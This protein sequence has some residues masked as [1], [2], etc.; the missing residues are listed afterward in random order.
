MTLNVVIDTGSYV[1]NSGTN[2]I[3]IGWQPC[4]V[5][6][7]GMYGGS[8]ANRG[9]NLKSATM[10]D[11]DC[12]AQ[13]SS[14]VAI[15]ANG[16]TLGTDGFSLG[17]DTRHNG[18]GDDYSYCALRAGPHVEDGSYTG[19]GGTET[20]TTGRQP[21]AVVISQLTQLG[22]SER[23]FWKFSSMAGASAGEY[24]AAIGAVSAVTLTSTGFQAPGDADASGETFD[25]VAFYNDETIHWETGSYAGNDSKQSITTGRQPN[26]VFIFEDAGAALALIVPQMA[27]GEGA[28]LTSNYGYDTA[29]MPVIT[30]TG[31][32]LD[33]ADMNALGSNYSWLVGY[34]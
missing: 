20:V 34:Q 19:A 1:G 25:W 4:F 13:S 24:Q 12:L 16:N 28:K 10:A 6:T 5:M 3:S 8:P 27:T 26:A 11:D 32:D 33:G 30:A 14:A 9:W 22:G 23:V 21:Y 2:D 31:F 15:T 29:G 17:S 7:M 18:T